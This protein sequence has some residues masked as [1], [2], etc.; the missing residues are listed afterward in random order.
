MADQ[1]RQVAV[2][3]D[4]N[5]PATEM[6]AHDITSTHTCKFPNCTQPAKSDR[7]P[8]SKCDE[9]RNQP[10]PMRPRSTQPA[11]TLETQLAECRKSAR[12]ADRLR[13][14][15]EKLTRQALQAK[16]EAEEATARFRSQVRGIIGKETAQ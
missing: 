14:K 5:G 8:F 3:T 4:V 16:R 10:T 13:A 12:E 15:A 2:A 1:L 7:G 9:H 11:G 6:S